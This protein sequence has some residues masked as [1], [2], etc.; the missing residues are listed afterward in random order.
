MLSLILA[1]LNQNKVLFHSA[2]F[3][4]PWS[5]AWLQAA[6]FGFTSAPCNSKYSL[7]DGCRM[8]V[9]WTG[10]S[11]ALLVTRLT[12]LWCCSEDIVTA[13]CLCAVT[14]KCLTRWYFF[15]YISSTSHII[16]SFFISCVIQ[17]RNLCMLQVQASMSGSPTSLTSPS[18][19]TEHKSHCGTKHMKTEG[20]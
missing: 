19:D 15:P 1:P 16:F 8:A 6:D 12:N 2:Q 11:S 17:D 7:E 13:V 9:L 10:V 4:S 5:E 14:F 3:F 18:L 20:K